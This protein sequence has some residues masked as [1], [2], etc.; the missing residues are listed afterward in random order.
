MIRLTKTTGSGYEWTDFV[1]E[2][3]EMDP[4]EIEL[5]KLNFIGVCEEFCGITFENASQ[6]LLNSADHPFLCRVTRCLIRLFMR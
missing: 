5:L 6:I 1:K 2:A 3:E 4:D